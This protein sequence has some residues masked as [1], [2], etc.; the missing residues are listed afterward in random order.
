MTV[1]GPATLCLAVV[2]SLLAGCGSAEPTS[3]TETPRATPALSGRSVC[4]SSVPFVASNLTGRPADVLERL[5]GTYENDPG[6]LAVVFDG[7]K[8]I[9]IVDSSVLAEWQDWLAPSGVA[10][11]PSCVDSTLLAAV[12]AVLPAVRPPGGGVMAGYDALDDAIG[13]RGVDAET[14]AAALEQWSPGMGGTALS[15]I[16]AGTL[17]IDPREVPSLR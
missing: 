2:V 1:E 8:P 17:R 7:T 9:V 4:P 13:V 10:V 11:A 16:A 6:F 15:A 14:L 5:Q 3:P 12:H